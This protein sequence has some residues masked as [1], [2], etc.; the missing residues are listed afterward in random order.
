MN[1]VQTRIDNRLVHGQ[2]GMTWV[3]SNGCNLVVV[4][5]DE[6]ADDKIQ[7]ELMGMILPESVG[8]RFFSVKDA[9]IK[10]PKASSKQHI[11]LVLRSPKDALELVNGG[12]PVNEINIGNLHFEEGKVKLTKQIAVNKEDATSLLE[13][14]NLN[15]K[16]NT[17]QV[18]G[19]YSEDI[20]NLI[21]KVTSWK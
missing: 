3:N 18:P 7:Q 4:V 8:I 6:V 11:F 14:N 17:M 12:I 16:L 1:I 9:I 19:A 2:V 21:G 20:V 5:N 10:L 13:L 15:V